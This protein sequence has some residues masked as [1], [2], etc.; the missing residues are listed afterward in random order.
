MAAVLMTG[1]ALLAAAEADAK[2]VQWL[3]L[4]TDT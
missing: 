4:L 3:S 2:S 1:S